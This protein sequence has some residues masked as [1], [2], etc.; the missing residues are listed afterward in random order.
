MLESP[1]SEC[2]YPKQTLCMSV[3]PAASESPGGFGIQLQYWGKGQ[4]QFIL[5]RIIV[6]TSFKQ[7]I[8]NVVPEAVDSYIAHWFPACWMHVYKS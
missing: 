6:M 7:I 5:C 2:L 4:M 3:H 1:H 8:P